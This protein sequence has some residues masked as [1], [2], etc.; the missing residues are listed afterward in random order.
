M[1]TEQFCDT[2]GSAN[3]S[4]ERGGEGRGLL[5]FETNVLPGRAAEQLSEQK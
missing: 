4:E 1:G 5:C 3:T 2:K